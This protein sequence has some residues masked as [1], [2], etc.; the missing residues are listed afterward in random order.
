M[1][2]RKSRRDLIKLY[3]MMRGIHRIDNG[4]LSPVVKLSKTRRHS[5]RIMDK[6][7]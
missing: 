7:F 3:R 5:F 1:D 2:Y 6:R 4:K